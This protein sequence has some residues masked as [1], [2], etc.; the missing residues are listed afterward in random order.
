M[1]ELRNITARPI[2]RNGKVHNFQPDPNT[3]FN[4]D[5][6]INKWIR[7]H[8]VHQGTPFDI[9]FHVGNSAEYDSYNLKYTGLITAIGAKTVTITARGERAHRLDL[10]TFSWRNYD[11]DADKIS[12]HNNMMSQSI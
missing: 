12:S 9:T 6:K 3:L 4:A 8:G 1:I 11:F 5:I 2:T 7:L 10:Y